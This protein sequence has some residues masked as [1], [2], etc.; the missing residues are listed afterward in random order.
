MFA[1]VEEVAIT[2]QVAEAV[3]CYISGN[4]AYFT[5]R[6]LSKQWGDDWNDAP[7][8]HNAGTPYGFSKSDAE[9]GIDPWN[10]YEVYF[11]VD[12][13]TPC[14]N[15]L[16]SQYSVQDINN[17]AVPWLRS[18]KYSESK[19]INIYAGTPLL[20]FCN[21]IIECGGAIMVPTSKVYRLGQE[22]PVKKEPSYENALVEKHTESESLLITKIDSE[23]S[24]LISEVGRLSK[25]KIEEYRQLLDTIDLLSKT[26]RQLAFFLWLND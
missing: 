24:E 16:N 18:G 1:I 7:Y 21:R 5:T 9:K 26:R 13:E 12:L 19:M 25:Y 3:L 6:E 17:F 22:S 10:V 11:E 2:K 4:E 8:E 20:Y 23:I 14:D 15:E